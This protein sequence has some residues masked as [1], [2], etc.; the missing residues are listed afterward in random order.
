M[1]GYIWQKLLV[2]EKNMVI[3]I[4]VKLMVTLIIF[5]LSMMLGM[6]AKGGK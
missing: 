4:G 6:A 2:K 1:D 3:E 5:S